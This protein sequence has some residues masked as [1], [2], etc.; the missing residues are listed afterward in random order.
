M[1]KFRFI[2]VIYKQVCFKEK[3]A[4]FLDQVVDKYLDVRP[5]LPDGK[6]E[7]PSYSIECELQK[8]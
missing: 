1:L 2:N 4:I 8:S 3:H 5:A 6:I 7:I